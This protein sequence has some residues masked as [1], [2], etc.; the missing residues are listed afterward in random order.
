MNKLIKAISKDMKK[1]FYVADITNLIIDLNIKNRLS[2][3]TEIIFS[4]IIGFSCLYGP[5]I[6]SDNEEASI[7]IITNGELGS[8]YVKV[9]NKA[10]VNIFSTNEH[11]DLSSEKPL[12]GNKSSLYVI[13]DLKMKE[14]YTAISEMINNSLND[15]FSN[16][17]TSSEQ[18]P[19]ATSTG[20]F[21]DNDGKIKRVISFFSQ[22]LPGYNEEDISFLETTMKLIPDPNQLAKENSLEEIL[23]YISR[24]DYRITE[25]IEATNLCDCSKERFIKKISL[26]SNANELFLEDDSI[27]VSCEFCKNKYRINRKDIHA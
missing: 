27:E 17:M 15:S 3:E 20:I 14:K 9:N 22:L 11:I 10:N 21:L 6:L 25:E 16:F 19:T 2:K 1:R 5:S 4:Q 12:F 8:V 7:N 13:K 18:I 26:L 23:E 24:G